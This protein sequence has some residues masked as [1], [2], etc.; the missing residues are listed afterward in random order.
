MPRI[1]L[2]ALLAETVGEVTLFGRTYTVRSLD[3]AAYHT[4]IAME[5]SGEQDLR[6][7][8]AIAQRHLVPALTDE[9]AGRL[10]PAAVAE[11]NSLAAGLIRSV[12]DALPNSSALTTGGGSSANGSESTETANGGVSPPAG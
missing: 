8:Y 12:E 11:V 5:D 7:L 10:T 2:D 9:E 4:L 1:D 6:A 3:G